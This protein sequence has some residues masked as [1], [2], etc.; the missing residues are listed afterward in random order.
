MTGRLST[1][2][3]SAED[4]FWYSSYNIFECYVTY[5]IIFTTVIPKE[6]EVTRKRA[7]NDHSFVLTIDAINTHDV[8]FLLD[9]N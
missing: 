9:N 8:S 7:A 2:L 5:N 3:D 6:S 4:I 1:K